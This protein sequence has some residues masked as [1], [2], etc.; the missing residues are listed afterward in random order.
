MFIPKRVIFEKGSLDYEIGKNIYN[1]FKDNS[2]VETIKLTSNKVKENIPGE[3][4][5][6]FYRE[7]KKTLVVGV[8]KGF[9]F[10][11]CKPSA[12]YQLPIVSGCIGQCQYCYLNTNLGDRPY[13]KINANLDDILE[14][15]Q[16][17]IDERLPEETIFEGSATSDPVPIEPYTNA[18]KRTI[19]YFGKSEKGRFRFVTKYS[20]IDTLLDA[21]HNGRTE[22]RFTLN[23][24]KVI[25]EYENRTASAA[26]RIEACVKVAKVGYPIGFIIAPVFLYDNWKEDYRE[27]LL[28]LHKQL[29]NDL[30]YPLMFEVISHRYTTRAKNIILEVF[31]DTTLPM[32]DEDRKYKYGQF[33]YGKFV[34]TKEQLE[35]MKEFFK[36]EIESIF[37]NNIIKYII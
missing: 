34:Y 16:K 30:D 3:G 33:G 17:Y 24:D 27:L 35:E 1:K 15:A 4:L 14:Q 6:N 9:K 31:P 25:K 23:T 32:N 12:H 2:D 7:G 28:E 20:D 19:E 21:K 10:Q 36:N 37:E 8:K 26:K 18:L 22:I 11:S 29:P 5:F 13:I